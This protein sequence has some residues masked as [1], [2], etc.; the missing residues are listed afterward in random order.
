MEDVGIRRFAIGER[1][2]AAA[3]FEGADRFEYHYNNG[4][5]VLLYGL[6]TPKESEIAGFQRGAV[7]VGLC[8][9]GATVFVAFRIEGVCDWSDQS[10]SV[11]LLP[12]EQRA[13]PDVQPDE[14]ILLSMILVDTA[15]CLVKAMRVVTYSAHMSNLFHRL[16]R[17]QVTEGLTVEQ[18]QANVQANYAQFAETS[19]MVRNALVTERAGLVQPGERGSR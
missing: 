3:L 2:E 13:V 15:S 9:R 14:H 1:C 11:N 6:N 16:L 12:P 7:H 18:H 19:K 10:F 5:H 8:A 17:R 4:Q